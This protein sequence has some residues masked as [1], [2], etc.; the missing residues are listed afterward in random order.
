MGSSDKENTSA[1]TIGAGHHPGDVALSA[2]TQEGGD[3]NTNKTLPLPATS[4]NNN[5][6][7]KTTRGVTRGGTA[8]RTVSSRVK[9]T[10]VNNNND[11]AMQASSV[12]PSPRR[13]TRARSTSTSV[14]TSASTTGRRAGAGAGAAVTAGGGGHRQISEDDEGY[15]GTAYE[16][17]HDIG[18]GSRDDDIDDDTASVASSSL[19]ATQTKRRAG[20]AT[21]TGKRPPNSAS[22]RQSNN[23]NVTMNDGPPGAWNGTTSSPAGTS[24]AARN[25]KPTSKS[26]ASSNNAAPQAQQQ[27]RGHGPNILLHSERPK[28]A[29]YKDTSVNIATAFRQAA[30]A[31]SGSGSGSSGDPSSSSLSLH[32]VITT[33]RT[34]ASSSFTSI[35]IPTVAPPAAAVVAATGDSSKTITNTNF[36]HP[37]Q[38]LG[39]GS[40]NGNVFANAASS[41]SLA[42]S[43]FIDRQVPLTGGIDDDAAA[44]RQQHLHQHEQRVGPSTSP[45]G[46]SASPSNQGSASKKRKKSDTKGKSVATTTTTVSSRARTSKDGAWKPSKEELAAM[47]TDDYTSDGAITT[48]PEDLT[49]YVENPWGKK[50]YKVE[51]DGG[52]RRIVRKNGRKRIKGENGEEV[53]EYDDDDDNEDQD[54]DDEEDENE[55]DIYLDDED[56]ESNV[57]ATASPATRRR[58]AASRRGRGGNSSHTTARG[59]KR[60]SNAVPRDQSVE[61]SVR[62]NDDQDTASQAT[63][64]PPGSVTSYYLHAP[65][66]DGQSQSQHA[67]PSNHSGVLQP[68]FQT[69]EQARLI[70]TY[71]KAGNFQPYFAYSTTTLANSSNK[72]AASQGRL[73]NPALRARR[74]TSVSTS[75]SGDTAPQGQ[76]FETS[77]NDGK[78][79]SSTASFDQRPSDYDYAEEERMTAT[80]LAA[81][82]RGSFPKGIPEGRHILPDSLNPRNFGIHRT[83]GNAVAGTS[84]T[85]PSS[86]S[87]SKEMS[88]SSYSEQS[89]DIYTKPQS[90]GQPSSHLQKSHLGPKRAPAPPPRSP[91]VVTE[92]TAT[93]LPPGQ[94]AN[95]DG[96]SSIFESGEGES[97]A[98]LQAK[99]RL[100]QRLGEIVRAIFLMLYYCIVRPLKWLRQADS[101]SIIKSACAIL[102]IGLAIGRTI[103]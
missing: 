102:L 28:E 64:V 100:T 16:D 93:N 56:I 95:F 61:E 22:R 11:N 5:R 76:S 40:G 53:A 103:T 97:F 50:V 81:K 73:L 18:I 43:M 36:G 87:H 32:P 101:S 83:N 86:H 48:D 60:R 2:S 41:S 77:G 21:A 72:E 96:S 80:L 45:E 94:Y 29:S 66:D 27:Q 23:N 49:K 26:N 47:S 3:A 42:P 98:A 62:S 33:A 8:P 67:G 31:A 6:G 25:S 59:A 69:A 13:S 39:S 19:T 7:R 20:N 44:L 84:H 51:Y 52:R 9:T 35:S 90:T 58:N 68:E 88:L 91:S 78:G 12:A 75:T 63:N 74:A 79:P 85:F 17:D 99:K 15:G 4:T 92:S 34:S 37:S 30:T 70:Q 14:S 57:N 24:S 65:S 46:T 10:K 82:E 38:Q 89:S 71:P 55:Q 1:A 54:E